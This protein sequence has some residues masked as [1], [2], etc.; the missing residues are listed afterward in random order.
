MNGLLEPFSLPEFRDAYYEKAPLLLKRQSP[1]YYENL[2]TLDRLNE[3]IGGSRLSSDAL[4]LARDGKE[5][6]AEEFTFADTS[7]NGLRGGDT[8]DKDLLFAKFYE[9][10]TIILTEYERHSAVLL[11]LLHD[12]ERT[13]HTSVMSN[14]YLTPR[15]A[16]GFSAHWDTHD[17]FILQFSGTKD[18]MI[19][20]SPILLPARQQRYRGR[21]W[22]RVEP[23]LTA[24]LEPGDL[25]YVPRGFVHEARSQEAVSGHVTIGLYVYTYAHL[26]QTIADNAHADPWLRK[27]LPADFQSVTADDEFLRRIHRFFDNADL[28]AY[29][30]RLHDDFAATRLPDATDRLADYVN[31]PFIGADSRF[32]TRTVVCRELKDGDQEV[33]LSFH[34]KTLKFPLSAA[35]AI[36]CMIDTGEFPASA[37]PGNCEDNLALCSTLVREGFLS[38]V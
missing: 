13:F 8:V 15:N 21:E 22:T 4:R 7:P 14:V 28:P 16:Q 2:L 32:R 1:A 34:Q 12:I 19:Y 23:T 38:V 3:H 24:T 26:L 20:D 29:V 33:V 27:S 5:L 17:V 10:Y 6:K 18:W 36:R 35:E 11:R 31:L 37:L 9:G 25:L 30:E